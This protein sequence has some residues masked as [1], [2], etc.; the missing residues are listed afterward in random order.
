[1]E[2]ADFSAGNGQGSSLQLRRRSAARTR[3]TTTNPRDP[4]TYANGYDL[5]DPDRFGRARRGNVE[6]RFSELQPDQFAE[7]HGLISTILGAAP[8]PYLPASGSLK[9]SA[10]P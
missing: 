10:K 2:T 3:V 6:L 1:M 4:T 8:G 9:Q 7:T 5:F